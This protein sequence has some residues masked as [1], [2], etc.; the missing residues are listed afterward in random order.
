MDELR[1]NN[2]FCLQGNHTFL[3]RQ[4]LIKVFDPD[5]C[6][7]PFRLQM[8][9]LFELQ[10]LVGVSGTLHLLLLSYCAW[11]WCSYDLMQS[12]KYEATVLSGPELK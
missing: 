9:H 10:Q 3:H 12:T 2:H 6:L 5:L 11:T 4:M 8:A 7:S 1:P